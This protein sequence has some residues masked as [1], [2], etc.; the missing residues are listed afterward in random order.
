MLILLFFTLLTNAQTA[1]SVAP[2]GTVSFEL[3]DN[4]IFVNVMING[5]GPFHMILDTGAN[6]A[7]SPQVAEEAGLKSQGS[8]TTGGVGEKSVEYQLTH[9]RELSF[10]PVRLHDL[11]CSIISTADSGAVFGKVR[12]DG[13]FGLEVFRNY[14]VRHDYIKRQLFFYDAKTYAYSGPGESILFEREGN[15][16]LIHARFDGVLGRFGV[17]TGARSALILYGP[18]VAANHIAEKY[19]A[20]FQGISGWG[21]GGPVRSYMIRARSLKIGRFELHGLIA[22]LST[23]KSGATA[24]ADKAGLIGPDVLKQ[25]TFICDYARHRLIFEKNSHFGLRDSYDRAGMW[26]AQKGDNFEVYDVIPGGP[27]DHAGL[28]AGDIVL[29]ING[30]S[31]AQLALTDVRDSWKYGK[32]GTE[33]TLTVQQPSGKRLEIKVILR[34]LV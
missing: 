15:I 20:R 4:R 11:S 18:F 33:V 30:T 2:L 34:D 6:L 10:G 28:K 7:V 12:V 5:K 21:I 27:A 22:R 25:F 29:A 1:R 17:D 16:P 8:G 13:F 9:V 26:L 14:V 24:Q 23:N 3:I 32:P 31:T 19:Q